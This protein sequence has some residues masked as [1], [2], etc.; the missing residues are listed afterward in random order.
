MKKLVVPQYSSCASRSSAAALCNTGRLLRR[1]T[2]LKMTASL[3]VQ[4]RLWHRGS[5]K[6]CNSNAIQRGGWWSME[7]DAQAI[8]GCRCMRSQVCTRAAQNDWK[9]TS[10]TQ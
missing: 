6:P 4:V 7:W 10:I 1:N 3:K 5:S 8:S 2:L 9:R